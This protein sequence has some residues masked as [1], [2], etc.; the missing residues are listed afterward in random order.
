MNTSRLEKLKKELQAANVGQGPLLVFHVR[1]GLYYRG[2]GGGPET[3]EPLTPEEVALIE[4]DH[5]DDGR[6]KYLIVE[7][8]D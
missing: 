3:E 8:A 4:N 5:V 7:L 6:I 2:P 1:N